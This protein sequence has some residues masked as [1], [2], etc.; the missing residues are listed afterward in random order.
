MQGKKNITSCSCTIIRP[1]NCSFCHFLPF[2]CYTGMQLLLSAVIAG[3]IVERCVLTPLVL[4]CTVHSLLKTLAC[5]KTLGT[6][7]Y[8]CPNKY[9]CYFPWH[10]SGNWPS[11]YSLYT[12]CSLFAIS[13]RH[14][15]M[16]SCLVIKCLTF[17]LN[18]LIDILYL[19][20]NLQPSNC[21]IT[22]YRSFIFPYIRKILVHCA[23]L[24]FLPWNIYTCLFRSSFYFF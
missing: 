18:L 17:T 23:Y 24:H 1:E 10:I 14:C 3:F 6:T 21:S 11:L 20:A 13:V 5:Q 22:I 2:R 19:L 15:F 8:I 9:S 7:F 4:I 12:S 16:T